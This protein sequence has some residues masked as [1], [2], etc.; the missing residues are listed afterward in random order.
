MVTRTK[1]RA[2]KTKVVAAYSP[3]Y[4]ATLDA[5]DRKFKL[6][7]GSMSMEAR[8]TSQVSTGLLGSDLML[9]GGVVSGRWY[10]FFGGEGSAKSTHI[11]HIKLAAADSGVP[12][13][14]DFDYEG[15]SDPQ[16]YEGIMEYYSKLRTVKELYGVQDETTGKWVVP[17][18]VRYNSVTTAEDFFNS[19]AAFLRRIPDKEFIEGHW[20]YSWENDKV[21]K[22]VAGSKAS[23]AMLKRYGRLMIQAESGLPQAMYFLDSYPAM[24]PEKLDEDDKGVGMAAVARA[25]AEN[26]PKIF[27]KLRS[28]GVT[29]IGVNQLRLRPAVMFQN[30]EY[31]P[32]GEALKF[33]SSVRVRQAAR[34]VPHGKGPI[35]E[36]TSVLYDGAVDKYRY[37]HM[38]AIKNKTS[39]PYLESWQRIWIDDGTGTAH[40]FDPVW[41]TFQY[42]KHTGQLESGSTMKKLKIPLLGLKKAISWSDFKGLVL[43]KG[44]DSQTLCKSLGITKPPRLR[45]VCKKQLSSG[46]GQKMFFDNLRDS[47]ASEEE[48]ESEE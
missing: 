43:L 12:V 3:D 36:E 13:L 28:K 30:P 40:G 5:V 37:I 22:A 23:A 39:T 2:T 15:S 9:G 18:R 47:A 10:T 31:E 17:R 46:E 41:D 24:Y 8:L 29:I 20:W 27:S 4:G 42:L 1:S 44:K 7:Q 35:E 16:Y 32:G 25:M 6:G 33:A 48:E 21:G 11:A 26:I 14:S 19:T 34:S 45:E 38:K